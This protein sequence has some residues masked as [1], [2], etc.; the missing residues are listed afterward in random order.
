MTAPDTPAPPGDAGPVR[1]FAAV[2]P[3]PSAVSALAGLRARLEPAVPGLRWAAPE[4][5]HFTL[6]FF[7][8]LAPDAVARAGAVLDAT[9]SMAAPFPL[10]LRGL[11][12]FPSWKRPRVLWVGSGGGGERLAALARELERGFRDAGLGR[13]DKPFVPHLTLGRWRDT[14]GLDSEPVRS[15]AAAVDAVAAF[16]VSEVSV[17]RSVLGPRGA[18][19]TTLHTARFGS[20]LDSPSPLP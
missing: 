8:D 15:A 20:S 17:M 16:T 18:R 11:G 14:R 5:L 4:T 9:A 12:V 3:S 10:E 1:S 6:R 2:F 13:A 7:G 19:Y